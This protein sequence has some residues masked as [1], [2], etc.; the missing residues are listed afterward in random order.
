MARPSSLRS[1]KQC[2][3]ISLEVTS[4]YRYVRTMEPA[5]AMCAGIATVTLT[6]GAI[7]SL[8]SVVRRIGAIDIPIPIRPIAAVLVMASMIA[9]PIRPRPA[10]ATIAPPI[11][12]LT[13]AADAEGTA[14]APTS[15]V[16]PH[17]TSVHS[18]GPDAPYI[19]QPGDCLWRIA[20]DTLA[21]RGGTEPLS[22]E[23]ARF[24]P[25]IYQANRSVVGDDPNV[26][27][28]GQALQ[29]PEV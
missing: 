11:V 26:I 12:R 2:L 3:I 6:L 10:S 5:M 22:V 7:G 16:A 9:G 15:P 14:P 28:P 1:R 8:P 25:A 23:I 24:W 18:D 13:D 29:I 19:V 27:F 17:P 21:A 20:R 4:D